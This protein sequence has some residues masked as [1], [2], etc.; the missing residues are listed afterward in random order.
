MKPPARAQNDNHIAQ[1]RHDLLTPINH[2]LGFTEIQIEEAQ[3]AG[4]LECVPALTEINAGGRSLLAIIKDEFDPADL[5]R[6]SQRIE[7]EARPALDL[8]QKL[9]GQHQTSELQ[10]VADALENLLSISQE[11]LKK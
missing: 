11:M 10:L 8:A 6:L 4:L 9:A 7:S 3:E 5:A 2:I 1:L